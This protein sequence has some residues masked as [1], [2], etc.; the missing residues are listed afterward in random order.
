MGEGG[1]AIITPP[2]VVQAEGEGR[3]PSET[4]AVIITLP[5][6]PVDAPVGGVRRHSC[7]ARLIVALVY[8]WSR[9]CPRS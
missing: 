2:L 4:S 3:C 1:S 8:W 9:S 5:M 6:P 7:S